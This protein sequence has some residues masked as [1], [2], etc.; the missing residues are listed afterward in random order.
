MAS[1]AVKLVSGA[2]A[3]MPEV[4]NKPMKR[5]GYGTVGAKIEVEANCFRL[6]ISNRLKW[7]EVYDVEIHAQRSEA[8]S[9]RRA[10]DAAG[11]SDDIRKWTSVASK[12]PIVFNRKVFEEWT[13][14][15]LGPKHVFAY[16]GRSLAYSPEEM[17]TSLEH[18]TEDSFFAVECNK[19]GPV[20]GGTEN[21]GKTEIVRFKIRKVGSINVRQIL[22]SKTHTVFDAAPALAAIDAALACGPLKQ[23]VQVGRSF[24]HHEE[25]RDLGE[26]VEAWRGF[27]QSARLS[28]MGPLINMDESRTPFWGKGGRPLME[29]LKA[30]RMDRLTEAAT[31]KQAGKLLFGLKVKATHSGMTYRVQGFSAKGAAEHVFYD[32]QSGNQISVVQYFRS[33]YGVNI[34][35]GRFPCVITNK[36]KNTLVPIDV[37][38]VSSRQRLTRAMNPQQTSSMIRV[39]AAKPAQRRS[40]AINA[41]RRVNHNKDPTCNGFGISVDQRTVSVPARL[42]PPPGIRYNGRMDMPRGGAWNS[43]HEHKL[44]SGAPMF[45]WAVVNL[46]RAQPREVEDFMGQLVQKAGRMG[47]PVQRHS[48]LYR[49][50]DYEVD[51]LLKKAHREFQDPKLKVNNFPLQLIVIVVQRQDTGVYNTIKS[52]GDVELGVA[53][54]VMLVKHLRSNDVY[55]G[56]LLLK[57]NAKLGGSNFTPECSKMFVR[58]PVNSP[59][60]IVLGADVTHPQGGGGRPSVAALVCNRDKEY[61]QFTGAIRNQPGRQ[62][63]IED[64]GNMFREV[65]DRWRLRNNNVHC[66]SIIMFRDGVSEGQFASVMDSE[67]EAIRR[68]CTQYDQAFN[69]KVTYIIVTKRHHARFFPKQPKQGDRSGNIQAGTVIDTGVVSSHFYDFYLNSHAGIQGTSR[70]SKYT[71]LIDENNIPVD[72]LQNYI[73]RLTH[74]YARC[75]R[76][77]SMVNSAY[78]AHLLAFRGRAYLNDDDSDAASYSSACSVPKTAELHSRLGHRLFFV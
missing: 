34:E 7:I 29:L 18:K 6:Q 44:L 1:S 71:V 17:E 48:R 59:R 24:F 46:S 19:D 33:K 38:L 69:P 70:P 53:T 35:N 68:A 32:E 23:H 62:E 5:P 42:L 25:A 13:K 28:L 57:I 10:R 45:T 4:Q 41:M 9:S 21:R 40:S 49:G 58:H 67:L 73:Y 61:C 51:S 22:S 11:S 77:V 66:E 3:M 43:R 76:S 52:I 15:K 78:Y 30:M 12:S 26:G 54:Q 27:Y 56:N 2:R 60:T 36:K 47:M 8:S 63:I 64:M 37:L 14:Q 31:R 50:R 65:Y 39:A 75:N 72:A 74:A 16:D 20:A 55:K